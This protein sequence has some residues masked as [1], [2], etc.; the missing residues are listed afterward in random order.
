[1]SDANQKAKALHFF[2]LHKG[3]RMLVLPNAWDAASARIFEAG[4]FPALGTTSAGVA[5]SL[6]YRDGQRIPREEMMSAIRRIARAV[7]IPVTADVEAGYGESPEQVAETVRAVVEAGAVGLNLEDGRTDS[8]LFGLAEQAARIRGA[9]RA[10]AECG[11][12]LVINARTDV[13][14]LRAGEPSG[15]FEE[16]QR[17]L[18]A[19]RDAGAAC[20]FLPGV[21]DAH[22]IARMVRAV[23]A[24]LNVLA[25]PGAPSIHDLESMGVARLS[26]GSGPMRAAMG[27][28]RR[29]AR[30]LQQAGTYDALFENAISYQEMNELM[31]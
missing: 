27:A 20:L 22:T 8:A 4:G 23:A 18:L 19:Y 21:R 1:M 31:R 12:P 25:G 30:E 3:P 15:W 24:P 9:C 7:S 17:R 6:G 5:Y 2:R 26:L 10:A 29:I 11:V 13:Y 28:V 16:A 14:L